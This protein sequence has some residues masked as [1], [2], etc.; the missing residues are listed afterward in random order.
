MRTNAAKKLEAPAPAS[1]ARINFG[2]LKTKKTNGKTA[3]P[4]LPDEL[5]TAGKLAK[6]I[7]KLRGELQSIEAAE[8]TNCADL[9]QLV[10]QFYW[11]HYSGRASVESSVEVAIP[12]EGKEPA[13][14]VLVSLGSRFKKTDMEAFRSGAVRLMGEEKF[15]RLF[16]DGFTVKIDGEQI[17]VDRQ[18]EF[19]DG[20]NDLCV[21][22][23]CDN[24]V[25]AQATIVH[26]TDFKDARHTVLTE[27]ENSELNKLYPTIVSIKTEGV[28]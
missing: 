26:A 8:E 19:V 3:Y 15:G 18:Q 4:V 11:H 20:L 28:A 16:K 22:L 23:N 24:A 6:E 17:P 1:P 14:R 27:E 7:R 13:S 9:R 5:G 21:R 10:E 25:D 2:T 12:S